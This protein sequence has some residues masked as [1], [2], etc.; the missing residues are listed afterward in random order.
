MAEQSGSR[1]KQTTPTRPTFGI[2]FSRATVA[3]SFC[4]LM[5]EGLKLIP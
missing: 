2:L 5:I 4:L 3:L 1:T